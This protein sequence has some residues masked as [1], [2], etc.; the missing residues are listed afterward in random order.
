M[1]YLEIQWK[2]KPTHRGTRQF[3]RPERLTAPCQKRNL[4]PE[5]VE[6]EK[7]TVMSKLKGS[8]NV[9]EEFKFADDTTFYTMLRNIFRGKNILITGP[10]GCGKS[11]LGKILADITVKTFIVL[12]LVIL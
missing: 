5:V 1:I 6:V 2:T 7:D 10:S 9:P 4:P 3:I 11:S 12:T 8:V